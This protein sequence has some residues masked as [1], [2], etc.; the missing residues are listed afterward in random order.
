MYGVSLNTTGD[1]D[2]TTNILILEAVFK[3]LAVVEE[4]PKEILLL[5]NVVI[6]LCDLFFSPIVS[7]E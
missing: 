2:V 4:S 3:G 7:T 1:K 6:A 5:S